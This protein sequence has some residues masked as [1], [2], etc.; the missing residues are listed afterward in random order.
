MDHKELCSLHF[1]KSDGIQNLRVIFSVDKIRLFNWPLVMEIS[2]HH[3][4][5]IAIYVGSVILKLFCPTEI[6]IGS[7]L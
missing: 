5:D 4:K 3:R 7:S 2:R 1:G 6:S